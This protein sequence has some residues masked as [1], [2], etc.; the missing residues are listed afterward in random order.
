M[1]LAENKYFISN[2]FYPDEKDIEDV[3]Y[4]KDDHAHTWITCTHEEAGSRGNQ[5]C[6]GE[7]VFG[8]GSTHEICSVC[9]RNRYE[10]GWGQKVFDILKARA[11]SIGYTYPPT[12][13]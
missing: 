13:T 7:F 3:L 8:N 10:N 2:F 5:G 6:D 9:K 1:E 11:E 4:K 12:W